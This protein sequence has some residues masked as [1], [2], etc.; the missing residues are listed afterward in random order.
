[1]LRLK[2]HFTNCGEAMVALARREF[3]LH[4]IKQQNCIIQ[5]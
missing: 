5:V 2:T 4:S 1:M 3:K